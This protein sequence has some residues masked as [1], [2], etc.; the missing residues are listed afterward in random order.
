M[1]GSRIGHCMRF[2]MAGIVIFVFSLS[3]AFAQTAGARLEGIVK[4]ASQAVIP[5]VTVTATNE[6]T[7]ISTTSVTNESGFY[8]FVNLPP[9]VYTLE[10][11]DNGSMQ[12]RHV[13]VG[14]RGERTQVTFL[15]R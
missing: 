5:G 8:V 1:I 2:S 7:N 10:A 6:G 11:V 14:A 12:T 13:R 4:D 9:G 3:A 15:W